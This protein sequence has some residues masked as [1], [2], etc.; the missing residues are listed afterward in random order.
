M[1]P[2]VRDYALSFPERIART[3]LAGV[4]GLI[5]Q[6][7]LLILPAWARNSRLYQA[8]VARLLR[9]LVEMG[10]GVQGV[11]PVEEMSVREL[12]TRKAAGNALEM[13]SFVAVGWS[14][15]WMLAAAADIMGGSKVYLHALVDDL[16]NEEVLPSTV[17]IDSVE[18]LLTTLEGTLGHMADT[19]DMPPL[20][21]ADMRHSWS[22]LRSKA[23]SLPNADALAR[24]YAE[25]KTI[26]EH[27]GQSIYKTSSILAMGAV[28][29]G[30]RMGNVH[31]FDYYR[32]ALK[33]VRDEGI[34]R[35]VGR[36]S[37]PYRRA[38]GYHLDRNNLTYTERFLQRRRSKR[39]NK[40]AGASSIPEDV[41]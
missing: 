1:K 36:I 38:V 11:F 18:E 9:I 3:L 2:S 15:V 17:Q 19:V 30:A 39:R 14:P 4:G 29:T 41:G 23:S 25:L 26:A 13:V 12:A 6:L 16:R 22:E 21:V 34:L 32:T 35:Y 7:S 31:V 28:R 27:E 10:G 24:I 40:R 33:E 5:Y 8:T 37:N 20:N